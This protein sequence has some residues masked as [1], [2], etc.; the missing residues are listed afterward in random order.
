R[1]R[2]A[3]TL[4]E[5]L[6]VL[7]ILVVLGSMVGVFIRRAQKTADVNATKSQIGLFEQGLEM[8]QL[9]IKNYPTTQQGLV[10]LRELPG[11]LANPDKWNGPYLK[12][13]VP[14]D[15]WDNEYQYELIDADTYRIWSFGPDG[16]DG[17]DDDIES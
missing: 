10:A 15:A 6:L 3:F 2:Q 9:E 13:D 8:Y 14:R 16:Q 5:V 7:V 12:K 11:D 4:M 17:T 1:R